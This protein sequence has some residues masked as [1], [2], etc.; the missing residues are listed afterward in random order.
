MIYIT[1]IKHITL[2][3]MCFISFNN[4]IFKRLCIRY[5]AN[6]YINFLNNNKI[7]KGVVSMKTLK[8]AKVGETVKVVKLT[9]QGAVKRRIMDMGITKGVEIFIRKVAPL[10]DP[11]EVTV[12]GYELSLRKD[13]ASMIEVE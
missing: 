7:K 10:G 1:Y 4:L 3:A 9:G 5:Y 11:V 2:A 13:D 8:Q 6:V 12:R